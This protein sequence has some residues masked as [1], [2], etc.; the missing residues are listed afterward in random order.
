MS[1]VLKIVLVGVIV[2]NCSWGF[3][4]HQKINRLAV[5]TLPPEMIGFYKKNIQYL[6]EASVNPDRRRY[7]VP[8][9]AAKHYID[10]EDYGD[11]SVYKLPR[12]WNDAVEKYG[13]DSLNA[14]GSVPWQINFMYYQL[15][16]GFLLKDPQRILKTSAELGHYVADANVPLH[17][18]RNYD[19]QLT[20]QNGIHALWESRL[21]ELFF[22]DYDFFVGKAQY[23][24][25]VQMVAWKAI[26][27]ANRALDSVLLNEKQLF[28]KSGDKKF[29]FETKGKQTVKTVSALYAKEYHD[30]LSGMVE[31]QFRKSVKMVGDIWYTAWVDAG[32]PDLKIM[33]DYQPT[34]KELKDRQ[35]EL[36]L[37]K[38]RVLKA[39]DHEAADN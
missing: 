10:L 34:E 22:E 17:T 19:G 1:R 2:L 29:S 37:W 33:I 16:E 11:S 23:I 7:A 36:K 26:E 8:E 13:E 30:L 9:E 35:A 20:G 38:E 28:Q 14:R 4:A 32:Q 6:T 15:K 24:E 39:R 18:T 21:P 5:F 27:L 31:R 12:Y 3:F 25:N